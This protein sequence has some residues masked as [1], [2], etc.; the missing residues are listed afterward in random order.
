[1]QAAEKVEVVS[2]VVEK[3]ESERAKGQEGWARC[4]LACSRSPCVKKLGL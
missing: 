2:A 1:M 4:Q 3:G